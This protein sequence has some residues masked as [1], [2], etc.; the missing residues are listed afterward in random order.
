MHTV[1]FIGRGIL[2]EGQQEGGCK[3][4]LFHP[5]VVGDGGRQ[6]RIRAFGAIGPQILKRG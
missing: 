1:G 5:C 6:G 2:A 3:D 4:L